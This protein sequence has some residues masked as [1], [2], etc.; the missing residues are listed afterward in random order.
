MAGTRLRPGLARAIRRS[1]DDPGRVP[2]AVAALG[3]WILTPLDH[4]YPRALRADRGAAGG[5]LRPGPSTALSQSRWSR[6]WARADRPRSRVTW[7]PASG[8][9]SPRPASRSY[10]DWPWASTV[11]RTG[12]PS[13]AAPEPSASSA[14][15]STPRVPSSTVDSPSASPSAAPSSAS[16]RP[17]T[18]RHAGARSRDATASS[19][20]SARPPSWSRR[21]P[22]AGRSSPP[23]T[24]S[25]RDGGCSSPRADRSIRAS[26]AT[27]CSC[28]SRRPVRSSGWT[29]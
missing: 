21:R 27:S 24:R 7:P 19:A 20:G 18:Q 1:A 13:T 25:S 10:P 23:A 22:G 2:R 28:A 4:G 6:W 9:A 12:R 16:W 26:A 8:S 15:A 14:A 29:R 3:G 17:G 11:P 5:A